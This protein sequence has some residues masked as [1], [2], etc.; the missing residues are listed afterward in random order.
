M[1]LLSPS[2]R[3]NPLWKGS[4][5]FPKKFLIFWE[6]EFSSHKINKFQQLFW[7]TE[8]NKK[9]GQKNFLYFRIIFQAGKLK[10]TTLKKFLIFQEIELWRPQDFFYTIRTPLVPYHSQCSTCVTHQVLPTQTLSREADDF[11]GGDKHPKDV[12][13]PTFLALLQPV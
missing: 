4:Y 5:T 3:K 12:P 7:A 8:Q 2:S 10:K 9:T 11:L 1:Q 6:M 13:L